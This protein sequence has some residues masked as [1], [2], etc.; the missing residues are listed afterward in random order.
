MNRELKFRVYSPLGKKFLNSYKNKGLSFLNGSDKD[1]DEF[2]S[3]P[4]DQCF[5]LGFI[6]Q[7]Y[8]GLTD[9]N[10][11]EIYEGDIVKTIYDDELSTGAVMYHCELGAYRIKTKKHL[12][13]IVTH[14][15][16]E[17]K[18]IG[19]ITVADKVIGNI[20]ENPELLT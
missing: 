19:L 3:Y 16:V 15:F 13:P 5:D 7:Q 18:P 12:L 9:K 8:T 4:L 17:D 10:G 14:R 2:G 11:K 20:F 6:V 1:M